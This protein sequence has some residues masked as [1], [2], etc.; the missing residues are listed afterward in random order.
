MAYVDW[1]MKGIQISNCNCAT[2]C[3]CQF[4]SLP[5]HGNCRAYVFFQVDSGHFGK[6]RLDGLRSVQSRRNWAMRSL[7]I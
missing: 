7:A 6:V 5:T 4:N 1:R 2:G 3:P